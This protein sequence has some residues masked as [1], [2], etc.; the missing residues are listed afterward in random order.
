MVK[1]TWSSLIGVLG[2]EL[3]YVGEFTKCW[4]V[5]TKVSLHIGD[6]T[7]IPLILCITIVSEQPTDANLEFS[8]TLAGKKNMQEA[9]IKKLAR[10]KT[11]LN[12]NDVQLS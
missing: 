1:V 2:S 9:P 3:V 8:S 12:E 6:L 4:Q 5:G 11:Y 7:S 10:L